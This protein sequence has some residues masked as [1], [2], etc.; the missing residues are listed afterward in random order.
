MVLEDFCG[1]EIVW[2]TLL[3]VNGQKCYFCISKFCFFICEPALVSVRRRTL[4][5][6]RAQYKAYPATGLTRLSVQAFFE[7]LYDD[8][9]VKALQLVARQHNCERRAALC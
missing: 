2:Y 8:D 1:D 7:G 6:T 3:V 4:P 9:P 5:G